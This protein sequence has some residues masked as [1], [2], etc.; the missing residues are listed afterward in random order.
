MD[1]G[2][3]LR[4]A[5]L[6][7]G[8]LLLSLA[9]CAGD[10]QDLGGVCRVA[11]VATGDG[12]SWAAPASLV[13][14]LADSECS[15]VW[16][17]AGIYRPGAAGDE[18]A[19]FNV[20]AGVKV[21]GGFA[22]NE[23][24]R[25]QRDPRA[26]LTI[27]SGDIDENDAT[28]GADGIDATVPL[29]GSNAG[30]SLHVVTMD[31]TTG[32]GINADT[33][34]DGFIITAGNA[35]NPG[36]F[37]AGGIGGGLLCD[38]AG[39]GHQCSP[40]L[41]QLLFTGNSAGAGG[42]LGNFGL[43]GGLSSPRITG[44]T[45]RGNSA[46]NG[47]ALFD[48]GGGG[49]SSPILI[50]VTFNG[51]QAAGMGGAM[52]NHGATGTSNPVL[53]N[54]TFSG[55]SAGAKGGAVANEGGSTGTTSPVFTNV[56]MWGDSVASGGSGPEISNT[57]ATPS[58]RWSILQGGCVPGD[59]NDCDASV[60]ASDPLLG[61]LQDNGGFAPTML[62]D[63]GSPAI[64]AGTLG[65]CASIDERGVP[66]PQGLACDMGAVEVLPSERT[67]FVKAWAASTNYGSSWQ[68]AYR[69]LQSA[70]TDTSCVEVWV[71]RGIYVPGAEETDSFLV[72]PY[73]RVYGG[74]AGTEARLE[75]RDPL[76]NPTVLSGD[77]D[78]NDSTRGPGGIDE[79]VP[80]DGS[81]SGNSRHVLMMRNTTD[82]S[83]V[84]D[85]FVITAGN[86]DSTY[87]DSLGGGLLCSGDGI[88]NECN[89]SLGHLRFVGNHASLGGAIYAMGSSH[90]DSSPL[91]QSVSFSGNS[92]TQG[93]AMYSDGEYGRSSPVLI[94]VTF[95]GNIAAAAAAMYNLGSPDRFS[96]P[97]LTNVT[98]SENYPGSG[99][100]AIINQASS[101]SMTNVILW[102]DSLDDGHEIENASGATSWLRYS[103][104]K[105][106]CVI[107]EGFDCDATVLD[108]DPQLGP[109][110]QNGGFTPTMLPGPESVAIDE[111]SAADCSAKDQRGI[112]RPQGAACDIGAV[113]LIQAQLSVSVDGAGS[114]TAATPPTP[115]SGNVADCVMGGARCAATYV[116]GAAVPLVATPGSFA[117]SG[118]CGGSVDGS[119]F[120]TAPISRDCTVAIDFAPVAHS[121]GGTVYGLQGNSVTLLLS[122]PGSPPQQMA[123]AANGNFVFPDPVAF[124]ATYA[125]GITIPP[126]DPAESCT[127]L[128]MSGTVPDGDVTNVFVTCVLEKF[129]VGGTIGGATDTVGLSLNGGPVET[130]GD[131]PF[132]FGTLLADGAS[133]SIA[134]TSSPTGQNCTARN[135]TGII[136]GA[137]VSDVAIQCVDKTA[138]LA[139]TVD[140]ARGYAQYGQ[141]IDY[142]VTLSNTGSADASGVVLTNTFGAGLNGTESHWQCISDAPCAAG[143]GALN[144]I[145]DL[146]AGTSIT[147]DLNVPVMINTDAVNAATS[148][149]ATF[150]AQT[151]TA[152]DTDV[153]VLFRDG[154]GFEYG[155]EAPQTAIATSCLGTSIDDEST[156]VFDLLPPAEPR[157]I[158]ELISAIAGDGSRIEVDR[159]GSV[160]GQWLRLL[161]T[162]KDG[163][164]HASRWARLGARSEIALG[165][166]KDGN[167][168][169]LLL[170]GSEPPL[171]LPLAA[172]NLS[173]RINRSAT[174]R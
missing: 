33:V 174:C 127:I 53:S 25:E 32:G 49:T 99:S 145:V 122:V 94:N 158:H 52:Y 91:L 121:V 81:N 166:A 71:A 116:E 4:T 136:D 135:G 146:P 169:W 24:T 2:R 19:T 66:R 29:D 68:D 47:G 147:W 50:N 167:G 152:V 39:A 1:A 140:D 67:C 92:A 20:R 35:D 65:E 72:R 102:N 7:A 62:L 155:E 30:N 63:A 118:N 100:Y 59:G 153:L 61:P 54:V 157:A 83:T 108:A 103:I 11:V 105:G 86:A 51:N 133:Y 149:S 70:L 159:L 137:T 165:I 163:S 150:G 173:Y 148:V 170:A 110:Q 125:V 143:V 36:P 160:A 95:S 27:L 168:A 112:S 90:G 37:S 76:A 13:A 42:A 131:G 55:N 14:A 142:L 154:F 109:L 46:D 98:F 79:A 128:N 12:S 114:V 97:Q 151:P 85:G 21:Y 10:A 40:V 171:Q 126:A 28:G 106:G 156:Q 43:L 3:S 74:F 96:R 123:V 6:C 172:S 23:T 84:L 17:G 104:M 161:S 129:A 113:E 78:R 82:R 5:T 57:T 80:I 48:E 73:T 139:L 130:F 111:G 69:D 101:P 26:N 134:I 60:L 141:V 38:G 31:G 75:Q 132:A 44:V 115:R 77:I 93:G 107:G 56:I 18:A 117:V 41:N 8:S 16:V 162:T 119:T 87:T 15:E 64:D 164:Q 58:L 144:D 138:V 34:L 22:G 45:F 124:G 88:G 9:S 89:P 120:T